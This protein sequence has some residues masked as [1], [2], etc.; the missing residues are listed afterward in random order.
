VSRAPLVVRLDSLAFGG[1]AVGRAADGRVI[2]VERGAPGDLVEVT[3]TEE[4]RRFAR[5][6]VSKLLEPG[7]ARRPPPCALS[8]RCGGC[9]WMHVTDEA[10]RQA[11]QEI[12]RRAFEPLGAAVLPLVVGDALGGRAR[13]RLHYRWG[14]STPGGASRLRL[15]FL[16]RR[17]HELIDVPSCLVLEPRLDRALARARAALEEVPLLRGPGEVAGLVSVEGQLQ[18]ALFSETSGPDEESALDEVARL[19]VPDA[20]GVLLSTPTRRWVRG[21]P[22][23]ALGPGHLAS[24]D[25]FAQ[26]NQKLN[27]QLRACALEALFE[28]APARPRLLELYA[29]DGNL[30]LQLAPKVGSLWVEEGE[31][32]AVER[33]RANL[34]ALP[35]P[36]DVQLSGEP[37][38]ALCRRLAAS[39]VRFD[40]ILL[41]PPRSGAAETLPHLGALGAARIVYVSCDP[42]TLAR[43]VRALGGAGYR[44]T[45]VVPFDLMPQTSHVELVCVLDRG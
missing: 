38:G 12:V 18:L 40:R 20:V 11:K 9:S 32:R 8:E 24:A 30:T 35:G 13:A 28:S 22:L 17:S 4:K 39:G 6:Q 14:P 26:A 2:F 19:L 34:S 44:P 42:M 23:L 31:P 1:E 5:G 36:L 10:Q 41:D 27:V 29:G 3:L 7:A 25:G 45:R 15:G 37:A 21:Q 33:L 43:D 16:A